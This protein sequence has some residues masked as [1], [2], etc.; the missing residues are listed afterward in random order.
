MPNRNKIIP[1]LKNIASRLWEGHASVLVGAGFSRNAK[2]LSSKS[3]KFPMWTDLG[4]I[5]YEK[6]YCEENNNRYSNVLKLGDEVQAAFGRAVLDKLIQEN[7]PDKEYEPSELHSSLLTLPWVDVFTT[8]YDTLLE[9][10]SVSVDSRKYDLVMNKN[11]LINAERPRII[12]LHGSFP[13]E[14]PFIITEEDYRRYPFDNSPFVNT[15]Q[16]SLIENTLC[17]IGFSGDDP[18][19]LNWIGWIRDN[20]GNDNSPKIFIIGLFS[21]NE[22]QRKLLEKRNVVIVDLT[23]LGDF[24]NDHFAAHKSF[25]EYLFDS[26]NNEGNLDWPEEPQLELVNRDNTN[27]EKLEKIKNCIVTWKKTRIDYPNWHIVPEENRKKLWRGTENFLHILPEDVEFESDLDLLFAYE[28]LWRI[29]KSLLPIFDNVAIHLFRIVDK[30]KELLFV[31]SKNKESIH[32]IVD[33]YLPF[34][35][36]GLLRHCR[37]ES[38]TEKWN[39]LSFIILDSKEKITPEIRSSFEYESVMFSYSQ[40]NFDEARSKL[41]NWEVSKQLPYHEV[42]RAGLL[43]EFGML[44]EA[45][46]IIEESLSTIRRNGLLQSTKNDY[47]SVSQEAYVIFIL[48][49]LKNSFFL[50]NNERDSSREYRSRLAILSQYGAD[51]EY[52]AKYF[53]I[54]LESHSKNQSRKE[55]YDFDLDRRTTTTYFGF[56]N[57]DEAAL[58]SF[59]FLLFCEDIG[60]PF[61]IPTMHLLSNSAEISAR[62]IYSYCPDWAIFSV[63]RL[64]DAQ[65]VGSV[66]NRNRLNTLD[67]KRVE[68]LFDKYFSTYKSHV[69]K[70][71]SGNLDKKLE[72][73]NSTLSVVPEILSRLVTKCSYNKK[74]EVMNLLCDLYNHQKFDG[75]SS[76]KSLLERTVKNL[77]PEQLI[78][79]TQ[80]LVEF[81]LRPKNEKNRPFH[82]Y[83]FVNPFSLLVSLEN[84]NITNVKKIPRTKISDD[85]TTIKDGDADE[86]KMSSTKLIV[87]HKL[88]M[89]NKSDEVKLIKALWSKVDDHGFPKDTGY[90]NFFFI[91][92]L[93]LIENEIATK[94]LQKIESSS[95]PVQN[96]TQIEISQGH[97]NY[98]QELLGAL[99]VMPFPEKDLKSIIDKLIVW[100]E[101]DRHWLENKKTDS[102]SGILKEF[103]Q[104]FSN[105]TRILASIIKNHNEKI[106]TKTKDEIETLLHKMKTDGLLVGTAQT[107][108][109][110][111]SGRILTD[112]LNDIKND[113][114]QPNRDIVLESIRSLYMLL[115]NEDEINLSIILDLLGQKISWNREPCISECLHMATTI[116]S[117]H[118]IDLNSNFI[119]TLIVGLENILKTEDFSDDEN[120][121]FINYLEK[122]VSAAKLASCLN[123][124]FTESGTAPPHTVKEWEIMCTSMTEFEE[125]RNAWHDRD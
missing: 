21:F 36:L 70:S 30:Y 9:R 102:D 113:F 77:T 69:L 105:I 3:R 115:D 75:F 64:Y 4:D 97:S 122:K 29:D 101:S 108:L 61:H 17:L 118:K 14:R 43:A 99:S 37:Q 42:K 95:F 27:I 53:E 106:T 111:K 66:F 35:V 78:E 80:V 2:A 92:N 38:L 49:M 62:N 88:N 116:I 93:N 124:K 100:Y 81:P 20:L 91:K 7:V 1:L 96:G 104:R 84:K 60:L 112:S 10:A 23:F 32:H 65:R 103:K 18:N 25:F 125:I 51:P 44:E 123:M 47:T 94:M 73:E 89:L 119:S 12:K 76:T 83:S 90:Y 58:S 16:Q 8:N 56:I 74:I 107:I 109:A 13:S 98:C 28:L 22:A 48:R 39:E 40:L 86:R 6:V 24:D 50:K 54:K 46:S 85:L 15:V 34:I 87:L 117:R 68:D 63:F 67:R 41:A 33:E 5:F 26:K 59:S 71:I 52:E 57:V 110:L 55:A 19:F 11:D 72:V 45:I 31:Q 121:E 114:Y 120:R 82:R 79:L